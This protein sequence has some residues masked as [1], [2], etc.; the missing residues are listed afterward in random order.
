MAR[1]FD[2]KN[3]TPGWR[4]GTARDRLTQLRKSADET[5]AR[6]G[7]SLTWRA[8]YRAKLI[9]TSEY[10][11]EHSSPDS[12]QRRATPYVYTFGEP[13][14]RMTGWADQV[15]KSI[16]HTGW[17]L[18]ND[19][20]GSRGSMRGAVF[21]LPARNG[22]PRY[23]P[24]MKNSDNDEWMFWPKETDEDKETVAY[25]ADRY[26]ERYAEEE[27]E[28]DRKDRVEQDIEATKEAVSE[29]LAQRRAYRREFLSLDAACRATTEMTY[30]A[31]I[32]QQAD[33]ARKA[34]K[35]ISELK[36]QL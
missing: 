31:L 6:H 30:L 3:W 13:F 25:R 11:W 8:V 15:A 14:G 26:A 16:D 29:A 36:E 28:F 12:P 22:N 23:Y 20:D 1:L 32:S 9:D 17:F 33:H 19:G 2:T 34:V 4:H 27:R 5:N 21:Q 24:A 10:G 18:D 7:L 35:R